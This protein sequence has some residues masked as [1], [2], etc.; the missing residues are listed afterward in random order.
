MHQQTH[1]RL[2]REHQFPGQQP[3]RHAAGGI[4]VGAAVDHRLT[5]RLLRR[6]ERRRP[7]DDVFY[8]EQR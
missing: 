3:I 2:S 4:N 8:G 5:E 1:R 6:H 7:V